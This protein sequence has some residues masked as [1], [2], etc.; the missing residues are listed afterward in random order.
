MERA[1]V[2]WLIRETPGTHGVHD[3]PEVQEVKRFAVRKSASRSEFYQAGAIGLQ[4]SYVFVLAVAEEYRGE[5]KL[6][7]DGKLFDIIRAYENQDGGIELTAQR[8]DSE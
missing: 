3:A 7:Y 8:G 6:R 4:P 5:K 2:V 1:C